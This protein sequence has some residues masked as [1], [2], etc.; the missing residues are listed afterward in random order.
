LTCLPIQ[1]GSPQLR[2]TGGQGYR[3]GGEGNRITVEFR[4]KCPIAHNAE[5]N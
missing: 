4:P 1:S 3:L 2:E 5:R